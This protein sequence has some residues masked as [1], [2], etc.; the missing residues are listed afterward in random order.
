M[1]LRRRRGKGRARRGR[2]A[3]A[4]S[5]PCA[6]AAPRASRCSGGAARRCRAPASGAA[7]AAWPGGGGGCCGAQ[8]GGGEGWWAF[9]GPREAKELP[10]TSLQSGFRPPVSGSAP[11]CPVSGVRWDTLTPPARPA[12]LL[13]SPPEQGSCIKVYYQETHNPPRLH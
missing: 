9:A 6:P 5:A 4:G 1:G 3:A 12:G 11:T 10:Q 7:G 2:A 8:R 13:P